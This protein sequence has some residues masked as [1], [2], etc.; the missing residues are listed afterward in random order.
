MLKSW[1]RKLKGGHD[2][3]QTGKKDFDGEAI[4][5]LYRDF[6]VRDG[7][8]PEGYSDPYIK[9]SADGD[10]AILKTP[11]EPYLDSIWKEVDALTNES[12]ISDW[13]YLDSSVEINA[14]AEAICE[15]AKSH[16]EKKKQLQE[17]CQVGNVYHHVMIFYRCS[18][19]VMV[20]TE[21]PH[22]LDPMTEENIQRCKDARISFCVVHP[23]ASLYDL[24]EKKEKSIHYVTYPNYHDE[25]HASWGF[26]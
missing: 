20:V 15:W 5:A 13:I 11:F 24:L 2:K 14:A 12:G 18:E 9:Q 21:D 8:L 16:R 6:L 19:R 1:I 23:P 10:H 3:P 4:R 17:K 26:R 22:R 7:R 25:T